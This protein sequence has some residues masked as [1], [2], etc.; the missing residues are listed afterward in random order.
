MLALARHSEMIL[1]CLRE[2]DSFLDSLRTIADFGCGTGEDILWWANLES[3]D[4]PP[5]PYNYT[6]WAVD[7]DP[8]KLARIPDLPKLFKI[9]ADFTKKCLP[10]EAD[11]I[12]AHDVLQF[13]PNP[14]DTLRVWNEQMNVNGMLVLAV[15]MHTGVEYNK[16]YSRSY[17]GCYHNFTPAS[18]I[19]MLAVNGF[20]TR[21][22]YL[23]KKF[24]DPW[25]NIAVYKSDIA[26]KDPATTSWF[27][28]IPTNLLHPSVINSLTKFGHVRQEELL[29]PWLDKENYYVDWVPQLTEVPENVEINETGIKNNIAPAENTNL[30]QAPAVTVEPK[31]LKPTGVLRASKGRYVK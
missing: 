1:N 12:F 11:L 31:V 5:E 26:P 30:G 27:D 23:L 20:D 6:C 14:L 17:S 24:N 16:F 29:Y 8:V 15:P 25:I 21:D 19:Y 22:A 13:S 18:L 2:Y 28:L 10:R 4:E 7:N 9:N 3:R